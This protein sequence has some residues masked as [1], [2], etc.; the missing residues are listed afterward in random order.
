[1]TEVVKFKP[2]YNCLA[3]YD[4]NGRRRRYKAKKSDGSCFK[5]GGNCPYESECESPLLSRSDECKRILPN[6]EMRYLVDSFDH[7]HGTTPRREKRT[8]SACL[9]I[10]NDMKVDATKRTNA[11]PVLNKSIRAERYQILLAK[12]LV[13]ADELY[14]SDFGPQLLLEHHIK[15]IIDG[16][17]VEE[18]RST[19]ELD[20]RAK[21][22]KSKIEAWLEICRILDIQ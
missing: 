6:T 18:G 11:D 3:D 14:G 20:K 10:Y 5:C 8:C 22:W 1:M 19:R 4:K 2:E 17:V 7:Q 16:Q 13:R 15:V 12:S 9:N 21:E